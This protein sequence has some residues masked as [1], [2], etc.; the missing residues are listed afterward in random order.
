MSLLALHNRAN[1]DA[2]TALAFFKD[3]FHSVL[4]A[5]NHTMSDSTALM[6]CYTTVYQYLVNGYGK[7][8]DQLEVAVSAALSMHK[9]AIMEAAHTLLPFN[10]LAFARVYCASW[11]NF[12]ADMCLIRVVCKYALLK[13]SKWA[14]FFQDDRVCGMWEAEILAD[15]TV[16]AAVREVLSGVP[17]LQHQA[18]HAVRD[19]VG[20]SAYAEVQDSLVEETVIPAVIGCARCLAD[21]GF[22]AVVGYSSSSDRSALA[23]QPPVP[24]SQRR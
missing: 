11:E 16:S 6:D 7:E 8:T 20:G 22:T 19:T 18:F 13:G 5:R 2:S 14:E 12:W 9:A 21:C 24:S 15:S 17:Q 1:V 4:V 3:L 23:A 10:A